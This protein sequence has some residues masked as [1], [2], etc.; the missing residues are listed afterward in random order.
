VVKRAAAL[1]E[2]DDSVEEEEEE[3]EGGGG[4]RVGGRPV[5]RSVVGTVLFLCSFLFHSGCRFRV[6]YGN[7]LDGIRKVRILG[8]PEQRDR[9]TS[10]GGKGVVGWYFISG[11]QTLV[12]LCFVSCEFLS[13]EEGEVLYFPG[14]LGRTVEDE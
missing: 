12:V 13:E 9:Q 8:E 5:C 1:I 11:S 10:P 7:G 6:W 4:E 14:T 3:E 2:E